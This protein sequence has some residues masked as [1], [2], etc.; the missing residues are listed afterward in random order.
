MKGD[1]RDEPFALEIIVRQP[2][3]VCVYSEIT[4]Q[5]QK[6]AANSISQK[7]QTRRAS[8]EATE[9]GIV[10]RS[11][12]Y[13]GEANE[14]EENI[15]SDYWVRTDVPTKSHLLWCVCVCYVA[16]Y[17][18]M[19]FVAQI[20]EMRWGETVMNLNENILYS[21]VKTSSARDMN[22]LWRDE[23][24]NIQV[25]NMQKTKEKKLPKNWNWNSDELFFVRENTFVA[26]AYDG[27]APAKR[28][29]WWTEWATGEKKNRF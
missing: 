2:C 17:T 29:T 21:C 19:M 27:W 3:G 8:A 16:L 1:R 12:W 7:L 18:S 25:Q 13:F 6:R 5:R 26:I 14:K 11:R 20:N 9:D 15:R 23:Y 28:R 22:A 24:N 4:T 10:Y